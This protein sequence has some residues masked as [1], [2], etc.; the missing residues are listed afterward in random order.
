MFGLTEATASVTGNRFVGV[1]KLRSA[2][3][4]YWGVTLRIVDDRGR[5]LPPGEHG[6]IWVRGPNVMKGY[7]RNPEAT[8]AAIRDGWLRAGDIGYLD[9]DG[10]LFVVDRKKEMIVRGGYNVYPR[11]GRRSSTPTR[12]C[13]KRP[14]WARRTRAWARRSWPMSS[15]GSIPTRAPRRSWSTAAARSPSSGPDRLVR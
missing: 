5:P 11:E 13:S 15:P 12:T 4:P 2:G 7:F 8:A 14:S 3:L 6:E 1:R 10:F 9:E